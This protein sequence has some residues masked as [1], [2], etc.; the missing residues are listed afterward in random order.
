MSANASLS[1]CKRA[2][3][4]KDMCEIG[5]QIA[6]T[7]AFGLTQFAAVAKVSEHA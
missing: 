7:N 3:A 1:S 2:Y 6:L 4:R 5:G